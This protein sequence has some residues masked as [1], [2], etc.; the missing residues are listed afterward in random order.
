MKLIKKSFSLFFC[1]SALI[2]TLPF[3]AYAEGA[4]ELENDTSVTYHNGIVFI[5]GNAGADYAGEGATLV[6]IP[7]ATYTDIGT[8][9]YIGRCV[10]D[11][12]GSFE[13]KCK[14]DVVEDSDIFMVKIG[15]KSVTRSAVTKKPESEKVTELSVTPGSDNKLNIS[16]K[17]KYIDETTA[18]LIIATFTDD[19]LVDTF[20]VDYSIAFGKNGELQSYISESAVSGDTV[21]VYLWNSLT[22]PVPMAYDKSIDM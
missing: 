7:E 8:A 13:F 16:I 2:L 10:A 17:N 14:A 12:N 3:I 6:L 9:K 19:R 4:L 18:K 20:V 15:D 21:K 22:E 11:E 1:I 5:S